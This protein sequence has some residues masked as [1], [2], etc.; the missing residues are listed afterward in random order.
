MR[1][2]QLRASLD[3][4]ILA[5]LERENLHGYALT[6]Q[7][8]HLSGGAIDL[9]TGTIYPALHR[10]EE[11]KLIKSKPS[12]V[13]GRR[14]RVYSLTTRGQTRLEHELASWKQMQQTVAA[15]LRS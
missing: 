14:R 7:L 15:V 11:G 13:D 6:E 3:L 8:R 5:S 2:E 9:A 4:M 1:R 10:L 12:D